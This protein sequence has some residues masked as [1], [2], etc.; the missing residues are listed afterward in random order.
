MVGDFGGA[1]FRLQ[2]VGGDFRRRHQN[3]LFTR[4]RLFTA[5]REEEGHMGILLGFCN[6]QLGFAVFGQVIAQYV[7]QAA[8]RECAGC[9]D[10]RSVLGQHHET[11][12]FWLAGAGEGVEII[13][14]E[15]AGQLAGAVGAEVHKDHGVAVFHCHRLADGRG[16]DEFVAF[17]TCVGSFQ[18]FLGGSGVELALAVDDQVVGLLYAVPAIVTV[19]GEV[20]ADQ[21]GDTAFAQVLE[22]FVQQ[23]NGR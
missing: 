11:G 21:A 18:A 8:G 23:F 10:T 17:A 7:F 13:F 1:H 15:Y 3:A 2:V 16:F 14:N 5:A 22:R 12:Q 20:T 4:E 19:H 9:R 6:A